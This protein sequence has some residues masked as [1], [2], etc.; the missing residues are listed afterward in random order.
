M[1]IFEALARLVPMPSMAP[2]D[3][4]ELESHH[5]AFGTTVVMVTAVVN[6]SLVNQLQRLKRGG[7]RPVLLLVSSA[8][9][10]MAPLDGMPAYAIRIEDTR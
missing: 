10:P 3:F 9:Q 2:D 8:D 6:H 1:H 4:V 7:H 5:L